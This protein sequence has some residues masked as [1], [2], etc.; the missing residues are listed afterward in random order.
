[1]VGCQPPG[2]AE[3]LPAQ[4]G[5][6]IQR[7]AVVVEYDGTNY[8]GFQRQLREPTVQ[9]G[10]ELVLRQLTQEDCPVTGAGRTDSGVHARGQVVH[11]QTN[12]KHSWAELLRAM[13]ALLPDDVSIRRMFPVT[14]D[15]HARYSALSRFYRYMVFNR[16]VR[17]PFAA[18]FAH[19]VS[20]P[21]N[22]Q[23]MNQ[24]SE[25]LIGM[26]DF[27]S[28]G[29][30]PSGGH[31]VR[32]VYGAYWWRQGD[33]VFF[34]IEANAFLRRMVRS[35]VGTLLLV[36]SGRMLPGEF[37]RIL[38]AKDRDLAGSTAPPQGL[39]LERVCYREPWQEI[40]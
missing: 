22:V 37:G 18:R 4:G 20:L 26:H 36:G 29:Q 30:S 40:V 39:C 10:L 17:S 28:F 24:A 3:N 34:D 9:A 11:F 14:S 25:S 21:L 5:N 31:T 7:V 23:A 1:M 16:E 8:C 32:E 6:G 13:N 33:W 2:R 38:Q 15:F 35:L 12:W 19:Q 27:A